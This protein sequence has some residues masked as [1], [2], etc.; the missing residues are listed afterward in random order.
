[1]ATALDTA[2]TALTATIATSRRRGGRKRSSFEKL[3]KPAWY[4]LAWFIAASTSFVFFAGLRIQKIKTLCRY[5]ADPFP[6]RPR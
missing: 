4:I 2:V 6:A 3:A 1:M 5:R